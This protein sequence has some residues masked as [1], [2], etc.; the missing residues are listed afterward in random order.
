MTQLKN[1]WGEPNDRP[2]VV[3]GSCLNR[4]FNASLM[5]AGAGTFFAACQLAWYP[6]P[7][8]STSSGTGAATVKRFAA[9]ATSDSG[10][11]ARAIARPAFWMAAASA[12]FA[13]VECMA[14]SA[15]GKKDSWNAS[16]GGMA[17]GLV[18]GA[19]TKR[20]DIMTSTAAGL[21]LF[22]FALDFTGESTIH[23][24]SQLE[25][26]NKMYGVMPKVHKESEALADLKEKYPECKEL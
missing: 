17:A 13:S 11:I 18:I 2:H 8:T 5:G 25:M 22:M 1:Y 19:T 15:R 20:A 10:A 16:I 7:V 3:Q 24:S 14:E 26:R 21:G 23:E 12:A 4:T 9:N 6:D